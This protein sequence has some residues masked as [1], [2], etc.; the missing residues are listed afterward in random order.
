[1][2]SRSRISP[3]TTT[4]GSWRRT[5]LKAVAK[6]LVKQYKV[7]LSA[8]PR[9]TNYMLKLGMNPG[10]LP[11]RIVEHL[12]EF[13]TGKTTAAYDAELRKMLSDMRNNY[14]DPSLQL[15]QYNYEGE[16]KRLGLK[17][18]SRRLFSTEGD[19]AVDA[20]HAPNAKAPATGAPMS[21]D[22]YLKAKGH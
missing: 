5:C 12:S 16:R 2:A 17:G 8:L 13:A 1:M 14:V 3:T 20:S 4:S 10:N 9:A 11:E 7:E 15:I 6:D 19:V 21:L 18:D 22:E